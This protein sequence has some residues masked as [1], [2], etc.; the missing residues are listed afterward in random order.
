MRA[1]AQPE[2]VKQPLPTGDDLLWFLPEREVFFGGDWLQF[3]CGKC[4]IRFRADP[5]EIRPRCFVCGRWAKRGATP[6]SGTAG[7]WRVFGY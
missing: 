6:S 2:G 1:V 7:G 5:D 3:H 4:I